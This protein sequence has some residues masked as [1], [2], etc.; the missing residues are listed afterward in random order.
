MK[1]ADELVAS[2][3]RKLA[4]SFADERGRLERQWAHGNDVST[5]DLRQ[6]L[7]HYRSFFHRLLSV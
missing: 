4:Q 6:A 3:I 7:R 1:E 5:E 2:G